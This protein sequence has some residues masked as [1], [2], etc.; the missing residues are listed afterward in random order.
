LA[1]LLAARLVSV[2]TRGAAVSADQRQIRAHAAKHWLGSAAVAA[3]VRA[4][5]SR[6]VES[7]ASDD[8]EAT[9]A[10]LDSVMTVTANQLDSAARLE[11][12]R[13]AQAIAK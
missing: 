2:G 9:M 12:G 10:A 7:T 13:L 11:L 4:A 1:C 8:P 6:L 5:L 3:S